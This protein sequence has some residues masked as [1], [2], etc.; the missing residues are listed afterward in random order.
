MPLAKQRTESSLSRHA[1]VLAVLHFLLRWMA[2]LV[3]HPR[4][5]S[6]VLSRSV[7]ICRQGGCSSLWGAVL[8]K[9]L[10]KQSTAAPTAWYARY[11]RKTARCDRPRSIWPADAPCIRI[12]VSLAQFDRPGFDRFLRSL[13]AQ[14]YPYWRLLCVDDRV[15]NSG[16]RREA[17]NFATYDTRGRVVSTHDALDVLTREWQDVDQRELYLL[18]AERVIEFER[19]ALSQLAE[20]VTLG[21]AGLVYGDHVQ[22]DADLV[23]IADIAALPAFSYEYFLSTGYLTGCV[24][25]RGTLVREIDRETITTALHHDSF[26][27]L[28]HVLERIQRATHVPALISHLRPASVD[29]Q[30]R[31][32]AVERHLSRICAAATV[33]IDADQQV[34]DIVARPAKPSGEARV[35]II[36]PTR[37]A[38]E[39][40]RQCVDS[41]TASGALERAALWIVDHC[42]DDP[43]ALDYL[44]KLAERHHVVRASGEFNFSR[45]VNLGVDAAGSDY[46]YYLL[47]NNDIEALQPG[48]LEHLLAVAGRQGVGAVGATLVYPD[49]IIQ[50]AGVVLGM[51]G[52]AG[53]YQLGT[54]LHDDRGR[55]HRGPQQTLVATR[56]VSAVTAACL[57]V[58]RDAWTAVEGFD[59]AIAVG[60]GDVDFCLRLGNAGY[61]ILHDPHSV[62]V[63][64]ES[65]SRGRAL[66]DPHPSDTR[67][68]IDRYRRSILEGDPFYSPLLSNTLTQCQL[69]RALPGVPRTSRV[70]AIRPLSVP[71]GISVLRTASTWSATGAA[72]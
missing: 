70:T 65:R 12:V 67:Q 50:H 35:A 26:E 2:W 38:V 56:E 29:L 43:L 36:V 4:A 22:L 64:H 52:L 7:I 5:W 17:L 23:K 69:G 41:L 30:F 28:L 72:A 10:R 9:A 24:A 14:N 1:R 54:P 8:Y 61:R 37:N 63:H 57:L 20:A 3:R 47:L 66:W 15:A 60:Y 33:S 19:G 27:L 49:G 13:V 25:V 51:R 39:L 53:H 58:D 18:F 40:L 62:L 31:A 59:E 32:V 21:H 42:T 48:W 71:V 6:S 45:L 46:S 68:F 34:L 55:R 16:A 44:D 11:R